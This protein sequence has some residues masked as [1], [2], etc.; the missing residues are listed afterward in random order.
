MVWINNETFCIFPYKYLIYTDTY[1]QRCIFFFLLFLFVLRY[2]YF[3]Y[4]KFY[5]PNLFTIAR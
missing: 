2:N 5:M 4:F 3:F 1:R